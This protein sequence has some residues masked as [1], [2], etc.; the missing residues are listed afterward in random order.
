MLAG[1]HRESAGALS[2]AVALGPELAPVALLAEPASV[3]TERV[4]E[5]M[6]D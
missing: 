1:V 5:K 3:D 4:I 2:E 6:D